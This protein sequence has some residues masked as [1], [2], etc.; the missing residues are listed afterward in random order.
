[1][2]SPMTSRRKRK[3]SSESDI[4]GSN[5]RKDAKTEDDDV[6]GLIYPEFFEK[7]PKQDP[8][9]QQSSYFDLVPNGS[10][11]DQEEPNTSNQ[12]SPTTML[13]VLK[14]ICNHMK[15][16]EFMAARKFVPFSSYDTVGLPDGVTNDQVK[17]EM[18]RYL[19]E[20]VSVGNMTMSGAVNIVQGYLS[21]GHSIFLHPDFPRKPP[22]SYTQF[23]RILVDRNI[24]GPTL[25][26]RALAGNYWKDEKY[27]TVRKEAE[28][29]VSR[30]QHEYLENLKKFLVE[31]EDLENH[32]AEY[33]KK[34]LQN[35]KR[36]ISRNRSERSEN[37][38]KTKGSNHNKAGSSSGQ[39]KEMRTAFDFFK[40]SRHDKYKDLDPEKR[41]KKLRKKFEKLSDAEKS[42]FDSLVSGQSDL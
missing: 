17:S 35:V 42:L 10:T 2:A 28:E 23:V 40:M 21:E 3:Y 8:S 36:L 7:S 20:A 38:S 12:L 11:P 26:S 32:H 30:M 33:A 4:S 5:K 16:D 14:I 34:L 1:M 19:K 22:N 9:N 31:H 27:A 41:E 25:N 18:R 24:L 15:N 13:R 39:K 37:A 6:D 29:T